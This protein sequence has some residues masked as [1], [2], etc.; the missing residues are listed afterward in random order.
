MQLNRQASK[1]R[2]KLKKTQEKV[3]PRESRKRTETTKIRS[4]RVGWLVC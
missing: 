1:L 3:L 2:I 4:E